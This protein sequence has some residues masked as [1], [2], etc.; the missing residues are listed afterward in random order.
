MAGQGQMPV[1]AMPSPQTVGGR[2]RKE[3]IY[4]TEVYPTGAAL[5]VT[6]PLFA[7]FNAYAVAPV[8]VALTKQR[9]RDTNLSAGSQGLPSN[10]HLFWY[11]WRAKYN[12]TGSD[13]GTAAN[14]VVSEELHRVIGL[15]SVAFTFGQTTLIEA[16][17]NELPTG[18]GPQA[19]FTTHNA[20]TVFS[21]PNGIPD[22]K[23]KIVSITG[24]PVSINALQ[25]FRVVFTVPQ[26]LGMNPT[27]DI[28]VTAHLE[29]MLL[30]GITG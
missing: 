17:A 4:D 19:T 16:Q 21:L 6:M 24:K 12:A 22:R 23:G 10:T 5:R 20:S 13:L 27:A 8:T 26:A 9:G 18:T 15:S 29:G 28:F 25:E 7:A 30:R 1:V 11:E 2:P 3:G 14:V